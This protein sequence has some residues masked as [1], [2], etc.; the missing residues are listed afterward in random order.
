MTAFLGH[1]VTAVP[2]QMRTGLDWYKGSAD[3]IYQN[4]N[5]I[6]DEEPDILFVFGADHVYRMDR[7]PDARLPRRR[8]R[9][10][11]GGRHPRPHRAGPR[12]R[13]HRGGPGRGDARL[14]GEAERPA[15]DA[16]QPQDVPGVDGQ[17]PLHDRHAGAR[18]S[19]TPTDDVATTSEGDVIPHAHG[20]PASTSTTSRPTS[21]P[22]STRRSAAT[23]A[24]SGSSTSTSSPTWTWWG[25]CPSSTSTTSEWPIYSLQR[26]LPPA[27]ICYG[28]D[29]SAAKVANS[30]L[31]TGA[32]VSGARVDRSIIGPDVRVEARARRS[33]SRS[34][35]PGSG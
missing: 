4:L 15:A 12:V 18:S 33:T 25:R 16:R 26:P 21:S 7:A 2:A 17:L 10:L 29:G 11:H 34:C 8:R 3:A 19:A 9:G 1:Y 30:L 13:R 22:A 23:G 6:T 28:S 20:S 35:C 31:C 24:T 32:I 14:P 5:I 27:K